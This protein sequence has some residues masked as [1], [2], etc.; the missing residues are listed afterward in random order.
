MPEYDLIALRQQK[1][2]EQPEV[3]SVAEELL[4]F[5]IDAVKGTATRDKFITVRSADPEELMA[6]RAMAP[7]AFKDKTGKL[8]LGGETYN[9]VQTEEERSDEDKTK[10]E[11]PETTPSQQEDAVSIEEKKAQEEKAPEET[12]AEE[13][14][15]EETK[16]EEPKVEEKAVE[17]KAEEAPAE[18]P[19]AEVPAETPVEEAVATPAVEAAS[20]ADL[21]KVVE[22]AMNTLMEGMK[23]HVTSEVGKLGERLEK[24]EERMETVEEIPGTPSNVST[25]DD[26]SEPETEERA[27]PFWGGVTGAK[28]E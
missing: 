26:N 11:G 10:A 12:K 6:R 19:K 7:E 18:E 16:A 24:V 9:V 1:I 8:E 13:T 21:Q 28:L 2:D 4:V 27:A 3:E 15:V 20:E 14:P 25:E 23:E 22:R 5:K 17:P